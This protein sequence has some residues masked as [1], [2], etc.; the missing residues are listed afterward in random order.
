MKLSCVSSPSNPPSAISWTIND[1]PMRP[2]PH[3]DKRMTAGIATESNI[4]IDSNLI[5][6]GSKEVVVV[7]TATNEEGSSSQRHTIRV[8]I[9]PEQPFIYGA[10]NGPMLEGELLNLTCEA[11]GGN[12]PA[13][14]SWY[15][16]I[17]KVCFIILNFGL[18]NCSDL[19]KY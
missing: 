18:I 16:G 1:A 12:P 3:S 15:R 19:I 11:T 4:T 14:L 13:E 6:S 10:E 8:L 5:L 7:C 17:E 9:P 2:Q